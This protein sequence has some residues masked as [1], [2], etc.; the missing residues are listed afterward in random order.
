[1]VTNTHHRHSRNATPSGKA[2]TP[3]LPEWIR[4]PRAG[5]KCPYSSLS[6]STLNALILPCKANKNRPVVKSSVL[7]QPGATRGVRLIHRESLMEYIAANEEPTFF[8]DARQSLS[9]SPAGL[10]QP[11]SGIPRIQTFRIAGK[12]G[13]SGRESFV[14]TVE[15]QPIFGK[16]GKLRPLALGGSRFN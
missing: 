14:G 2:P 10:S 16:P 3:L 1:M 8:D 5:E 11:A 12:R 6:R 15:T 13:T 7:P 9:A 4:L